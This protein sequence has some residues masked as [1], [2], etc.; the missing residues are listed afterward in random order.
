MSENFPLPL[1]GEL[2]DNG[3]YI[4]LEAD[5]TFVD[6]E[7]LVGVPKGFVSNFN[8]V[9]RGLWNV[10][11]PWEYPEAG[12]VHDFLY[13]TNGVTR[14]VAD[15]IHRRILELEGCPAW[16]RWGAYSALRAFGAQPWNR[17]REVQK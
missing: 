15:Q 12:V 2:K 7:Y 9:P 17:Y 5:F 4:K 10:F 14:K 1:I 8:S 13:Q 6:G 11:P 3:K 16:K